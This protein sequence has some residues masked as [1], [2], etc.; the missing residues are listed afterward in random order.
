MFTT[1]REFIEVN[2][3]CGCEIIGVA[4]RDDLLRQIVGEGN[5]AE[6]K[7]RNDGIP[8]MRKVHPFRHYIS[9]PES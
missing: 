1:P 6:N 9:C 7:R 3:R 2:S 5:S 8:H 4:D